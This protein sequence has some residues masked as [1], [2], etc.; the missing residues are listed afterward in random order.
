MEQ[1]IALI[2]AIS[3][4]AATNTYCLPCPLSSL[5]SSY[6]SYY[7]SGLPSGMTQ[8]LIFEEFPLVSIPFSSWGCY[9]CLFM[10]KNGKNYTPGGTQ[11]DYL[12][13]KHSML[14]LSN[15]SLM[16]EW[17]LFFLPAIPGHKEHK[18]PRLIA[19]AWNSVGILLY[20]PVKLHSFWGPVPPTLKSSDLG[21]YFSALLASLRTGITIIGVSHWA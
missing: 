17:W 11:L 14:L 1:T 10:V 3:L 15:L 13:A 19:I 5:D 6:L 18:G 16:P 12:N 21:D 8:T 4:W 20:S 7:L 9:T 2:I